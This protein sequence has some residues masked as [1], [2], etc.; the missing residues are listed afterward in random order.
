MLAR[1]IAWWRNVLNPPLPRKPSHTLKNWP[2]T[3]GYQPPDT[4]PQGPPPQGGS[5]AVRLV[6]FSEGWRKKGGRNPPPTAEQIA[7]RPPPPSAIP[8]SGL[9]IPMP[10]ST[11]PPR[12]PCPTCGR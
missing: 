1:L 7:N 5:G 9:N 2:L 8:R 12:E 6:G 3:Y 4:G 10:A 11:K